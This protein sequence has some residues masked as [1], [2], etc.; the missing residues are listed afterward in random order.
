MIKKCLICDKEFYAKP[1]FE[2]TGRGK[3]CSKKCGYISHRRK[4]LTP[5]LKK[6][7][8]EGGIKYWETH[9]RPKEFGEHIGE[10]QRGKF[11]EQA[12]RWKGGKHI[13]KVGYVWISTPELRPRDKAGHQH[14][15]YAK[16]HRLVMEKH[17]DRKLEKFETIH[18]KNG[19]KSDNR[20][21]NLDIVIRQ[22]HY[23]KIRCPH[24]LKEFL[25]K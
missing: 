18:H 20:I 12:R 14:R 16:E 11:G 4:H 7:F 19:I 8:L 22:K 2:K 10:I 21:E 24:C 15:I 3:Y 17:L 5:E 23:G 9:K 6:K 1:C 13:D 25:I